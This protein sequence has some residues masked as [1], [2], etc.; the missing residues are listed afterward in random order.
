MK[1][2]SLLEKY[3][4]KGIIHMIPTTRKGTSKRFIFL[5]TNAVNKI[6]SFLSNFL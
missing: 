2:R 1:F 5:Y 4:S 6:Y 3:I